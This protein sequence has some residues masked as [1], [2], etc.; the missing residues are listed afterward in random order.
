[1]SAVVGETRYVEARFTDNRTGDVLDPLNLRL[2]VIRNN[3]FVH[4]YEYPAEIV[5]VAAGH[6]YCLIPIT[7]EG[8]WRYRWQGDDMATPD[9]LINADKSRVLE[10]VP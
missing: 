7:A 5:R 2:Y 8:Q 4:T 9:R 10:L 1:M 6:Y 3:V